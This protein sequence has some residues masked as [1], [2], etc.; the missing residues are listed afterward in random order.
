MERVYSKKNLVVS[1]VISMVIGVLVG[2][3]LLVLALPHLSLPVMQ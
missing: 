1:R 3:L 2:V